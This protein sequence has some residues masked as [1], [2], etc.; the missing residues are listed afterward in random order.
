[1]FW[2]YTAQLRP[3]RRAATA[4]AS[5]VNGTHT[6]TSTPVGQPAPPGRP[7]TGRSRWR[8]CTSSSCRPRT[9]VA[10]SRRRS[11][12]RDHARQGLA[13]DQLERGAA[14]RRDVGD[15]IGDAGHVHGGH[16]VAAADDR[17][18]A[19]T[20][21]TAW[22]TASVPAANGSSSNTPIGPFQKIVL[23]AGQP[24][25]YS[26]DRARGRCRAP[27]SRRGSRRPA[28]ARVSASAAKRSATTTSSAAA[29]GSRASPA[30]AIARRAD[31]LA[32]A[33]PRAATRPRRGRRAARNVKAIA[34]PIRIESA[35]WVRRSMTPI[36]SATL[37][38]PITT[39]NGRAGLSSR[40]REG[41]QLGLQQQPRRR[42][43]QVRDS[44]GRGVRAVR[45]AE[46][47]VARR[48]RRGRPARPRTPGRSASS[49]GSKRRFSS[50]RSA[51]CSSPKATGSPEQLATAGRPPGA[52]TAPARTSPLGRPRCEHTTTCAPSSQQQR[53]VGS[54]ARMRVSSAT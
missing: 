48:R 33:R 36:L 47:V 31:R 17:D 39:T 35:S 41:V 32:V 27:S 15:P 26:R 52:A 51:P 2:A 40:L 10:R 3:R 54:A 24:R 25:A 13:L 28:T 11:L 22:A 45:G 46:R 5:D 21:A 49:R 50:S 4:S 1:M 42:R 12:Q 19:P 14:A 20:P 37:T 23:G 9:A 43:Q 44:L 30:S 18:G 7:R 38:P 8:S 29:A 34:P 53:M 6:A 16:R